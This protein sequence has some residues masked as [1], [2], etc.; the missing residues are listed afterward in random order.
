MDSYTLRVFNTCTREYEIIEVSEE[1]YKTYMHDKWCTK[2]KNTKYYKHH[3]TAACYS[4]GDEDYFETIDSY[5]EACELRKADEDDK[6]DTRF[7]IQEA[8]KILPTRDRNLIQA[9]FF[10][11]VTEAEYA[12]KIGV[13][14]P[15][16]VKKKKRILETLRKEMEKFS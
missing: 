2:K 16:V 10:N 8:M 1:V 3:T 13:S 15:C 14:Q 12:A 11:G 7:M 4:M 9:L 6:S 5:V